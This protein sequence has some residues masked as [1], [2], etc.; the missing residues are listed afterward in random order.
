MDSFGTKKYPDFKITI[1]ERNE[2]RG[3]DDDETILE[4]VEKAKFATCKIE[5]NE[6]QYGSGFFCKIPYQED[7]NILINVL[8][9]CEHV[10][11]YDVV[12]SDKDL[13][14]IVNNEEKIISLKKKRKRWS[15]KIMDYSCIEI[16]KEDNIK[17]YYILDDKI[18]KDDYS[19]DIYK[20]KNIFIFNIM[21]NKKWGHSD[22]LI[23]DINKFNF[24]HSCNIDKG[25]SGGVIVNK[26]NNLVIGIHEGELKNNDNESKIINIGIFIKD[27]IEDIKKYKQKN[28]IDNNLYDLEDNKYIN[29]MSNIKENDS[30]HNF[31]ESPNI[32][33]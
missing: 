15:N 31:I 1:T 4:Y 16:L 33:I 20:G 28:I 11:E 13:K 26:N 18:L 6:S 2:Y 8:L 32:K 3:T 19:N 12:F 17:D 25:C 10:L 14:I 29:I 9:T 21:K 5:I 22:G 27:I 23:L 30:S 7:E 24:Y